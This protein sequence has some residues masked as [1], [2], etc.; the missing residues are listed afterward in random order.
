M[1]VILYTALSLLHTMILNAQ[2]ITVTNPDAMF[3]CFRQGEVAGGGN[4][5]AIALIKASILTFGINGVF[6]HTYANGVY[7]IVLKSGETLE[8]DDAELALAKT[9]A[10]F[11]EKDF[12]GSSSNDLILKSQ[13]TK[14]A[15]LCFAVM[16]KMVMVHGDGSYYPTTKPNSDG[17][18][19]SCCF[20]GLKN[21]IYDL[22]DGGY[23]P[24]NYHL[25]GLNDYTYAYR[26]WHR[27][28]NIH[29]GLT[30]SGGH[31]MFISSGYCDR[32]GKK[33]KLIRYPQSTGRVELSATK[34][35]EFG[36]RKMFKN[37]CTTY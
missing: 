15:Y 14:Y 34:L 37:C 33:R 17:F 35:N 26:R 6:S 3:N 20:K 1:K 4:C 23:T 27:A 13:I 31:A 18:I 21:A 11:W 9:E 7:T 25:L 16:G 8:V 32:Y 36:K 29:A 2:I 12:P 5:A 30:Y 10:G 22:N 19:D 28:K 24:T